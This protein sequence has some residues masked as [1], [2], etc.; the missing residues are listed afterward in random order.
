MTT[1]EQLKK[2]YDKLTA[3]ER[4]ALIL[5]ADLRGDI[6]ERDAL[7]NSAPKV[8]WEFPHTVGL[9]YGF[10]QLIKRH[11]IHQLGTAGTF[12][13]LIS[14]FRDEASRPEVINEDVPDPETA[15]SLLARRFLEDKK[16]FEMVCQEY[17]IDPQAMD[18]VYNPFPALVLCMEMTLALGFEDNADLTDLEKTT[19]EYRALIEDSR[20]H[21]AENKAR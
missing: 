17:K 14:L 10:R 9:T 5:S 11:V 3:P 2:H 7:E 13:A 19:A 21:W 4:F 15:L 8:N 16:A 20:E 6:S 1:I 12:F 18:D